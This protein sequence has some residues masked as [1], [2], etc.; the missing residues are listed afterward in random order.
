MKT[1][2]E[3]FN[4]LPSLIRTW[5]IQAG[6]GRL[7]AEEVSLCHAVSN[8]ILWPATA[9]GYKFWQGVAEAADAFQAGQHDAFNKVL[10]NHWR[11]RQRAITEEQKQYEQWLQQSQISIGKR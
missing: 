6:G 4:M 3:W 11:E 10:N 2:L 9:Q 7:A 8:G 1:R 5:A